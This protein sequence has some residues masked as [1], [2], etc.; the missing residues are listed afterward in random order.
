MQEY[1]ATS[2]KAN[3]T[4]MMKNGSSNRSAS[5]IYDDLFHIFET[6]VNVADNTGM[7]SLCPEANLLSVSSAG[8]YPGFFGF[9]DG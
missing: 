5:D 3:L 6:P 7:T 8:S 2:T 9:W 4:C 1:K